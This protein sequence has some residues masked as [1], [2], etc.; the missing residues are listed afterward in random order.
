MTDELQPL[1]CP[2]CTEYAVGQGYKPTTLEKLYSL[3]HWNF[4]TDGEVPFQWPPLLRTAKRTSD[5]AIR[6]RDY[7]KV[8]IHHL[9]RMRR[10]I[11]GDA[12]GLGKTVDCIGAAAYIKSKFPEVKI[13]VVT[14]KSTTYQ[15][16][17]EFSE[18]SDMRPYVMKDSFAGKKSYEARYAQLDTFFHSDKIDVMICKYSSMVGKRRKVEGKWDEQGNPIEDKVERV[19]QEI[20]QFCKILKPYKER[21][22]LIFDEAHKFKSS[23]SQTRKLVVNLSNQANV[24]WA[25]TATA[26]KNGLDEFYCIASAIG[27]KPLGYV[28]DFRENFCVWRDIYIG[29][30]R[31]KPT[32]VG[33]KNV[34]LFKEALRPFFLGR[35]QRQVKEPLPIL[36]TQYHPIDLDE[37]Q[38]DLL[39]NQIPSGEFQLPPKL[40]EVA[41][42]IYEKERDPDN[43][44]TMLSVYQ[45]VANH[46]CLL[47]RDN[48]KEFYSAR[49]SPKEECLL[50]MLD[51][52]FMGE[53]V[54]VYTK[55]RSWIDRLERIT[56]DGKFTSRKVLR[57]TGAESERQRAVNKQLFQD[58]ESGHDIIFIN[59]AGMEGLNLQ[60]AAH[61]ICLDLP[62]S[63][64]D[65]I[66]LVGR[67]VR[68]ASLNS[69]CTLHVL[70]ARGTIDEYTIETLKGKKG[71]FEAILGESH[72]A[73]LLD[74]KSAFDLSSGMDATA[75]DEEFRKLLRAHAKKIGMTTFLRGERLTKALGEEDYAM[76]YEKK[77]HRD[78]AKSIEEDAPVQKDF[79]AKWGVEDVS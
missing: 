66:Q 50:D 40:I 15:W 28:M 17:E 2:L 16:E 53:K 30:G 35:S 68:M 34:P 48:V 22:I 10:F 43:L 38:S 41:G 12:V 46:P 24:V 62:W 6:L 4:E 78:K 54:I 57:I 60:S 31:R 77:V 39:L 21:V 7:Q 33:Y 26:I 61:M 55:Y 44:M 58:P 23:S 47:D 74:D 36:S 8:A 63:W 42:E 9:I 73:G 18:F 19:S 52:D 70:P 76:V 14:T 29:Q 49:L 79:L 59:A 25:L 13:I 72:S 37:E 51:G 20:K 56:K 64:G 32:I 27:I 3:R 45:L 67:M 69:T 71:V 11:L 65:L 5:V 75:S 1:T